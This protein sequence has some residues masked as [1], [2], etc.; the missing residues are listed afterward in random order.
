M[1]VCALI[2]CYF[3]FYKGNDYAT[4]IGVYQTH[5]SFPIVFRSKAKRNEKLQK[6][7]SCYIASS[8]CVMLRITT[9]G[10]QQNVT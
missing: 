7:I 8:K 6:V 4:E 5:V 10:W 3:N 1:V 9:L 2:F